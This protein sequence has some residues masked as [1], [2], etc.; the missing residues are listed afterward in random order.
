[1]ENL[2]IKS[3]QRMNSINYIFFQNTSYLSI[4]KKT[5][6]LLITATS[7][8]TIDTVYKLRQ[9]NGSFLNQL[10]KLVSLLMVHKVMERGKEEKRNSMRLC[11]RTHCSNDNKE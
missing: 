5:T 2:F 10:G 4:K 6:W 8:S 1:M 11:L 3:E 9:S 7:I